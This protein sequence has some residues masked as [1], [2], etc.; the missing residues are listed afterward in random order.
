[1]S[2]APGALVR[3]RGRE[4]VVLPESE[5]ELLV[6][7]PLGGTDEEIAGVF[8]PLE[9][10]EPAAFPPPSQ[11]LLGDHASCRMLRDAVRL[12]FRSSSGPFRSF[13]Q[14]AVE[15]RPY[16]LVPLL[17]AMRQDIVR[18]LIADD[19]GIGKTIEAGLIARELLDRGEAKRMAVLCPPPL[20]EQWQ[21]ELSRKFHIET[22]LVLASTAP[23]LER[24]CEVGQSLFELYK[25][26]VVSTDFIKSDRRRDD[27]LRTC[28]ELVIVDE[29]HTCAF[30]GGTGTGRHQRHQLLK[31]LAAEPNRHLILVTATPHSGK[32]SAFRS[33]LALLRPE[34]AALPDTLAGEENERQRRALAQFVVQRRRGDLKQYLDTVTP[35]PE[36]EEKEDTY[37]L[38]PEYRALFKRVLAFAR[39]T[40]RSADD[41][42]Q[43]QRIRWW[44][45]LGLLRSLASSPAA[46]AKTLRNRADEEGTESSE[47]ADEI[48]RRIIMD[49]EGDEAFET[50]DAAPGSQT[51]EDG[52]ETE[53]RKQLLSMAEAADAL[54]G[55]KDEKLKR[56]V[57]LLK[58][59]VLDDGYNPIVFCRFI[60]TADY[61]AE[62]LRKHLKG[63]AVEAV[64][65]ELPPADREQRV[66][67]LAHAAKRVLVAT[68]CLSEGI[69]LQ[70]HFDAVVH[71][72][73]AWN[74]TR[75]EQ[76]EGRV[77]RYGQDRKVV[78]VLTYYGK[79]NHI[80][81][82]VLDVLLRKHKSIRTALGVSVPVP[83][84]PNEVLE[85]VF[86][87]LFAP[88]H[89]Q[90]DLFGNNPVQLS[91]FAETVVFPQRKTVHEEWQA[92]ADREKLSR[93]V[94]AQGTIK[95]D[96]VARELA[97]IKNA[98][99]SSTDVARFVGDVLRS[100]GA[101]VAS[102]DGTID[103]WLKGAPLAIREALGEENGFKARFE[104]PIP[105]GVIHLQRTHPM[106]ERLANHVLSAALDTQGGAAIAQRSGVIETKA[107]AKRTTLL[108]VRLRFHI[109]TKRGTEEWP[110]L[111]EDCLVLGFRGAAQSAEWMTQVDSEALLAA[112]PS[113]NV[114]PDRARDFLR[115]A[116]DD[117][118]LAVI[119]PHL[120]EMANA[121]GAELL[122]AHQ[123]VREAARARGTSHRIQAAGEPDLL[124]LFV[125]LPAAS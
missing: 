36:R 63:V 121:R 107:V 75:H 38:S 101:T 14:L 114:N 16:Q 116:L 52:P 19:V 56:V 11:D 125:L 82:I 112:T 92:A 77:D 20:A 18:L 73:L 88:Q 100:H 4:W 27:F 111:A 65:G 32:E 30:D 122:D 119:K 71:Y 31:G 87:G 90:L 26:V 62:H 109:L 60:P 42:T 68:D 78:R 17:M 105:E 64:T 39:E 53:T 48:G 2:F 98:I 85:A 23:R 46:A 93:T 9:S 102:K 57:N 120:R 108:L 5:K 33:L 84:A 13:A 10:V 81:G 34:F 1:M 96:D 28:P 103:V 89:D 72:D 104:L 124:G 15:P 43:R 115:R 49:Q 117:T 76:R 61:L 35:F 123:R 7:R 80:D 3:A 47:A 106:V 67:Q 113:G 99:G 70:E 79:D 37:D 95:V 83:G 69:N 40:V 44:A 24:H 41:G 86:Q 21:Q 118:A 59:L 50:V 8:L 55:A 6:L 29:A 54:R 25:Y 94:Y 45:A 91:L 110:L 74:P 22:E 51:E 66:L 58:K 97:S 12:G